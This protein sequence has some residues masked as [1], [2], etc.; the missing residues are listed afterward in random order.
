[1]LMSLIFGAALAAAWP[2]ARG[3]R[4]A[5]LASHVLALVLFSFSALP[6][7]LGDPGDAVSAFFGELLLLVQ[8]AR[9]TRIE[10]ADAASQGRR[11]AF[12]GAAT[13]AAVLMTTAQATSSVAA[14]G[15]VAAACAGLRLVPCS[16]LAISALLRFA[17]AA[18]A[19]HNFGAGLLVL[20][21]VLTVSRSRLMNLGLVIIGLGVSFHVGRSAVA[22]Q[23]LAGA[24]L[25]L[26]VHAFDEAA[27]GPALLR[28]ARRLSTLNLPPFGGFASLLLI[29]MALSHDGRLGWALI[30][31]I[32]LA[33]IRSARDRDRERERD[34]DRSRDRV[35]AGPIIAIA[36]LL[37]GLF[38]SAALLLVAWPATEI[39]MR[40]VL[41]PAVL[42]A[43][44]APLAEAQ[45]V[46]LALVGGVVLLS[47]LR[48]IALPAPQ[49][50]RV[51]S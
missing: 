2:S 42:G 13:A 43:L 23:A 18:A 38:P 33:L 27:C 29:V 20:G 6:V 4:R 25:H 36:Q 24:L 34:R 15:L 7:L 32:G 51:N 37:V 8:L 28:T 17:P 19:G 3:Q 14:F 5:A 31:V 40:G 11:L 45:R 44:A 30:G 1:M 26:L 9:V 10:G 49:A 50:T 47:F 22:T 41:E 39:S 48:Q 12:H 16:I 35:V 46:S 21:A